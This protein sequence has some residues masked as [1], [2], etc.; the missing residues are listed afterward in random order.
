MQAFFRRTFHSSSKPYHH[1][2]NAI[3][4]ASWR[5]RPFLPRSVHIHEIETTT[6]TSTPN[7]ENIE[8]SSGEALASIPDAF[9][10][11]YSS[12]FVARLGFPFD[13]SQ[14]FGTCISQ[15]R[16][17]VIKR[18]SS[19]GSKEITSPNIGNL[20]AIFVLPV[21]WEKRQIAGRHDR[22]SLLRLH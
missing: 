14:Y 17:R 21:P 1:S 10:V 4:V 15:L 5:Q 3:E 20:G 11:D 12:V 13:P 7:L 2:T 8:W 19:S 6:S 9:A 16:S 18:S 22:G